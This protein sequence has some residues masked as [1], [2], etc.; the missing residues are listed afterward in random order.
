MWM[1]P[2]GAVPVH[3]LNVW[4][5][6]KGQPSQGSFPAQITAVNPAAWSRGEHESTFVSDQFEISASQI[7][8]G[9]SD[10]SAIQEPSGAA[11]EGQCAVHFTTIVRQ[12]KA[13]VVGWIDGLGQE[14]PEEDGVHILGVVE[15][16]QGSLDLARSK[17]KIVVDSVVSRYPIDLNI[18]ATEF[19]QLVHVQLDSDPQV[20]REGIR[21]AHR[22]VGPLQ[23]ARARLHG[24]IVVV[25]AEEDALGGK[26]VDLNAR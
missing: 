4:A 9:L 25:G 7:E 12:E 8:S 2:I 14:D 13:L 21:E 5:G 18:R 22:A 24:Q 20:I 19:S 15:Q 6:A 10:I 1:L 11:T 26:P 16:T 3:G 23:A 17:S